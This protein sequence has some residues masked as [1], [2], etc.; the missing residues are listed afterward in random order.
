MIHWQVK[1]RSLRANTLY[2][3]SIYD[4][5]YQG[6]PVQL[7][8]AAD[9]FVTEEDNDLDFFKPVRTQ[10]G[11]LNIVD[12]GYDNAGNAFDWRELMPADS[13]DRPVVLTDSNNNTL[14]Q[15]YIEPQTFTAKLYENVQQRKFPVMCCLASLEGKQI[16]STNQGIV[17]FAR[18]LDM[19]ITWMGGS[20]DYINFQGTDPMYWLQRKIDW[21]NF[22]NEESDGTYTS[23]YDA[24][25]LLEEICKFWGWTCRTHGKDIWLLCPDDD[26]NP[27][28]VGIEPTD[29]Y[30]Y[31]DA[32]TVP[33]QYQ[34][35]EWATRNL[36]ADVY[37]SDDNNI[38][39][40]PGI[41]KATIKANINKR[42]V[43]TGI[44]YD[45]IIDM[46]RNDTV[47]TSHTDD[48]YN[49]ALHWFGEA[50][51][52][53][54]EDIYIHLCNYNTLNPTP[55][56]GYA[57]FLI[58][59]SYDGDI[60]H[61][62]NYNWKCHLGIVGNLVGTANEGDYIVLVESLFP[63]SYSN[64]VIAISGTVDTGGYFICRLRVGSQWWNGSS[65]QNSKTTFNMPFGEESSPTS[66]A[67]GKIIDNRVLNGPYRN[68]EGY[69]API[70][71]ELG[72]KVRFEIV[73]F[74]PNDTSVLRV[75]IDNLEIK[76][77][78]QLSVS[79]LDDERSENIYTDVS[80]KKFSDETSIDTIFASDQ[81]NA[82]GLGIVM[83]YDGVYTKNVSYD[84]GD[85]A[86]TMHPEQH[87]L[88]RIINRG[89]YLCRVERVQV[90]SNLMSLT[91]YTKCTTIQMTGYP[92][93]ISH[94]WRDDI[95]EAYI[96]QL[97]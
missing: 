53:Y 61:K 8:G 91:P 50:A 79:E 63:H 65:W 17:T 62:H 42:E 57:A 34:E 22:L 82:F 29:L 19:I 87:L 69:G 49:F 73:G 90:R 13:Q 47:Q 28:Y 85:G 27:D 58:Q 2:T 39:Y 46:Y 36:D 24:L 64:G 52:Y 59:D 48:H 38:E 78:R 41:R 51:H 33:S 14:W 21:L 72:G 20:W 56:I 70:S 25:T 77:V 6:D 60:A 97:Q 96:M 35:G 92:M 93:S 40:V 74:E 88:N 10:T 71:S 54:F 81:N 1:F 76:F 67:G 83:N 37:A 26:L 12:T 75:N 31:L 32:G 4:D 45:K 94:H 16:P 11:Y 30:E 89:K 15:G 66:S 43:V 23:K 86:E 68:Y 95:T 18:I 84:Y 3:V 55:I 44:P 7:T 80:N 5:R 9:P